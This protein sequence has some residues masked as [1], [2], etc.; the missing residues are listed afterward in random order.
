MT[1][2]ALFSVELDARPEVQAWLA[3][4]TVRQRDGLRDD[5]TPEIKELPHD[6]EFFGEIASPAPDDTEPVRL[7]DGAQAVLDALR[8][9]GQDALFPELDD[10]LRGEIMR[11]ARSRMPPWQFR[12][13]GMWFRG[14]NRNRIARSLG[15]SRWTVRRALDEALATF[16]EIVAGNQQLRRAV[17][18]TAV[19]SVQRQRDGRILEWFKGIETKPGLLA[20]LALLLVLDELATSEK[21]EVRLQDV[22]PHFPRNQITPCMTVLRALAYVASDGHTVR[23]L[24]TPKEAA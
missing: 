8:R 1:S 4:L 18:A 13:F 22:L 2:P 24:K 17:M 19:K 10:G 9:G 12:A 5:P 3:T 6:A 7:S 16:A 23:V 11:I 15:V 21:R 14:S 20:P